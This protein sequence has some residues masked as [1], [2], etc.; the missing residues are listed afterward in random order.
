MTPTVTCSECGRTV[1]A[2]KDG[3][4]GRHRYVV[5]RVGI[6]CPGG[7]PLAPKLRPATLRLEVLVPCWLTD[8]QVRRRAE[9]LLH[10]H[11]HEVTVTE[12]LAG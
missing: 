7:N 10:E 1:H 12:V 3:T 8:N 4:P 6:E 5:R 2:R 9:A 11:L